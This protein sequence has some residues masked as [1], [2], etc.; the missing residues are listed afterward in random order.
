MQQR[1][2]NTGGAHGRFCIPT[3]ACGARSARKCA[4]PHPTRGELAPNTCPAASRR[5]PAGDGCGCSPRSSSS[6]DSQVAHP[7]TPESLEVRSP[8]GREPDQLRSACEAVP[9]LLEQAPE[10]LGYRATAWTVPL[11]ERHLRH[12]EGH[13][14]SG[15]TLR[16][17]L[18]GLGYRWKR[19][20][21]VL[22]RRDPGREE[23]KAGTP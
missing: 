19:P 15:S 14:V 17:A 8:P 6:S 23:K 11:L 12:V 16:R 20:R 18:H 3:H 5:R 9:R 2:R 4:P 1:G 22:A 10:A 13:A 21:F 7:L